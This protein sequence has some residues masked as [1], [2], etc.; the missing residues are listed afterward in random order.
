MTRT[1]TWAAL[2]ELLGE[3]RELI[4]LLVAHGVVPEGCD[5]VE[6]THV[7]AALVARTLVREL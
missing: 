3:D 2:C 7:D 5:T 6:D 1:R 4:E